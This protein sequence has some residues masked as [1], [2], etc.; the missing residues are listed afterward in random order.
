MSKSPVASKASRR[1][2]RS[3]HSRS[4]G[5]RDYTQIAIAYAEDAIDDTHNREHGKWIRL[6]AKRFW[7]DLK[8]A[9]SKRQPF[10]YS[11]PHA[12][13]HCAFIEQLP[14]VEGKWETD[15]IVLHAS[16]V[17]FVA[18][19]FGFRNP[20]GHRRFTTAIYA[21]AR[22]NA[23]ST[24]ASGILLSCLCLEDEPG[25]QVISAATTGSQA[26]IVFNVAKRMVEMQQDLQEVF[27]L[28]AHANAISRFEIGG[29]FKPINAKASTQDGLNP[30]HISLDEIHA[31]KTHDLL[32]VIRGAAGARN[33]P[34]YLYTTTEGYET[35]G[36]WP[37]IRG[38]M[39][40]VLLGT[41]EAEYLLGLYYAVDDEDSDFD[42]RAWRKAN[43]LMDVNPIILR[44]CR[45]LAIEAKNMPGTLSEFRIKRL[46][47]PAASAKSWT[48]LTKWRRGAIKVDLEKMVG[49]TCWGSFD[50][51]ATTD[52]V[53]WRLLWR[54]DEIYYTWGRFWVPA[55]AV[56]QRTERK[57][58]NYQ[59]WVD[60]GFVTM[61]EGASIDYGQ[62]KRDVL[63]D[64]ERFGPRIIAYD[65]WN[66]TQ[67]VNELV[68]E[69]VPL[70]EAGKEPEGLM[71]FIQG[72]RSYSPAMK[73]CEA[74]YMSGRLHHGGD[75]VLTWNMANV[76]PSYDANLNVRPNKLRSPDKID[77]AAALFM[78]FGAAILNVET[79]DPFAS[80]VVV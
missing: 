12:H 59:G 61:C 1:S 13:R 56:A 52:M 73:E 77:G 72:A 19:L 44:E 3:A 31:H 27:D 28:E 4:D 74:V 71:Q 5:P 38:L 63:H 70:A 75:P 45:K 55:D 26:R 36:P 43:P 14:H 42:E 76:V 15:T 50:L 35:P 60:A 48:N 8:R 2:A 25:A 57:S 33:S 67:F 9:Q 65:P 53:A 54:I 21:C 16:H 39:Q 37:E 7:K 49:E 41:V 68:D 20:D 17:F 23:K 34:L 40:S 24:V 69:G 32:N 18:Q 29:L 30:S 79:G 64:I 62:I 78:T 6:A 51:A 47:R 66:A 46:N 10:L 58:V 11:A 22:K 80:V